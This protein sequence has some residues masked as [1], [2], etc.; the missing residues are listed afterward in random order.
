MFKFSSNWRWSG[1]VMIVPRSRN[2]IAVHQIGRL[3]V[4][5]GVKMSAVEAKHLLGPSIVRQ[6]ANVDVRRA[7]FA[8]I[9]RHVQ[10]SS[11]DR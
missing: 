8:K 3:L 9:G 4:V 11:A 10:T 7:N 2:Q 5:F 1:H 6:L